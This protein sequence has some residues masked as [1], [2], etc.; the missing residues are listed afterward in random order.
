VLVVDPQQQRFLAT[1]SHIGPVVIAEQL[2]LVAGQST[3]TRIILAMAMIKKDKWEWLLQKACEFGADTIIP[4]MTQHCVVKADNEKLERKLQRWNTI[5]L[6]ACE[7]CK[8]TSLVK[9][10]APMTI[11]ELVNQPFTTKVVAYEQAGIEHHLVNQLPPFQDIVVVIGPE[12]GL[13]KREV[14]YLVGHGFMVVNLGERILRAES[15]GI[16]ALTVLD[17]MKHQGV[18]NA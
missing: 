12:G 4:L 3:N 10:E 2:Q 6:E 14:E 1:I 9:V 8:R 15:A 17:V 7:Q 5:T 13:A 16:Y 11:K 18:T